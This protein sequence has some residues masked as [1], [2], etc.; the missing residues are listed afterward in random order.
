MSDA[1]HASGCQNLDVEEV[2]GD[3]LALCPCGARRK[4]AWFKDV[5]DQ[6]L[7]LAPQHEPTPPLFLA[8]DVEDF[9][10]HRMVLV[11]I[12]PGGGDALGVQV[13]HID[14]SRTCGKCG[15]TFK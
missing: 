3:I 10:P 4:T 9:D 5:A 6:V 14:M 8:D 1:F 13:I 7:I 2:V 12:G 11:I 15:A